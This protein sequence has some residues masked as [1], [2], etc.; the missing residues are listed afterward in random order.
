MYEQENTDEWTRVQGCYEQ[1][2]SRTD[3]TT[4]RNAKLTYFGLLCMNRHYR[5]GK[6]QKGG[7]GPERRSA[8]QEDYPPGSIGKEGSWTAMGCVWYNTQLN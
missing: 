2:V 6:D 7:G 5:A 4:R 3:E 1:L 8:C